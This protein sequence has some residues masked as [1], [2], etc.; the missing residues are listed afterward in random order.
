MPE[1]AASNLAAG[2]AARV[3]LGTVRC[4]D[5]EPVVATIAGDSLGIVGYCADTGRLCDYELRGVLDG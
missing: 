2:W 4:T 3:A 5:V 1:G